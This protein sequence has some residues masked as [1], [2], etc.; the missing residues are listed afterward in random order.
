MQRTQLLTGEASVLQ[1]AAI[2]AQNRS[3]PDLSAHADVAR[4]LA[5]AAHAPVLLIE[6]RIFKSLARTRE[7]EHRHRDDRMLLGVLGVR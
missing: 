2:V 4:L 7:I 5:A 3:T 6:F 1:P